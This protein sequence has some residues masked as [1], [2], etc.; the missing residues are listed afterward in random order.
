MEKINDP[1]KIA[2]ALQELL[3]KNHDA[4]EV[5]KNGLEDTE[6]DLLKNFLLTQ[7]QQRARFTKELERE[8]YQIDEVPHNAGTFQGSLQRTWM[9]LKTI[10]SDNGDEVILEECLEGEKESAEE[11]ER[12]IRKYNF[13][14]DILRVLNGQLDEIKHTLKAVSSLKDLETY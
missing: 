5:F 8:I 1:K 12:A 3:E 9:D 7:A 13:S 10:F 4:G 14:D 6:S 2:Q 11:Y